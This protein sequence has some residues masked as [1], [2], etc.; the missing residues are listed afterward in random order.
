MGGDVVGW[1]V[2]GVKEEEDTKHDS[3]GL[4]MEEGDEE[5]DE[6]LEGIIV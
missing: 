6:V 3:V 4:D 2:V 1:E 5:V